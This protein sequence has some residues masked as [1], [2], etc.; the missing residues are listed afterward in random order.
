MNIGDYIASGVLEDY[1]LGFLTLEEEKKVETIC[2]KY[3]DVSI[4]LHLL[5]SALLKYTE[6]EKVI[7][8]E[9]LRTSIWT[10]LKKYFEETP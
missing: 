6:S 4:E 9:A 3:P 8:T 5:R 2:Q 1:C 10:A 7:H